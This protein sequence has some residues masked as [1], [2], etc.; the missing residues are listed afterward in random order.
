MGA[1][2][3]KTQRDGDA[4]VRSSQAS[5]SSA[6]LSDPRPQ[7]Q[8]PSQGPA[9][10][11]EPK[12]PPQQ[13]T[14][15]YPRS[16][17]PK[18]IEP[19]I[20]DP[21]MGGQA[22]SVPDE[23]GFNL[24]GLSLETTS[25]TAVVESEPKPISPAV[26]IADT[27][28]AHSTSPNR[29]LRRRPSLAPVLDDAGSMKAFLDTVVADSTNSSEVGLD[30]QEARKPSHE[31]NEETT[32]DKDASYEIT[33]QQNPPSNTAQASGET[34]KTSVSIDLE[35]KLDQQQYFAPQ[36]SSHSRTPSTASSK[37]LISRFTRRASK[38]LGR[39][40]KET[41]SDS[42]LLKQEDS[43]FDVD[44]II[45]RLLEARHPKAFRKSVCITKDE[46]IYL[47][48]KC[49]DIVMSQP[50]LLELAAP[51]HVAGINSCLVIS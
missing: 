9:T 3:S 11:R 44:D 23:P 12:S 40:S 24:R 38:I 4:S 22:S 35:V 37:S 20:R 6:S 30:K 5:L 31:V 32:G 2:G 39:T 41:G 18:T 50:N 27:E 49:L 47:C 34:A 33:D 10:A 8:T 29:S 28:S 48:R 13:E 1:G 16:P 46:I 25:T 19:L 36:Q 17:A 14:L 21:A 26:S 7:Q 15:K 43:Y 42:D 51:V 45:K